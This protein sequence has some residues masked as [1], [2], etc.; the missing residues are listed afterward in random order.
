MVL[1]TKTIFKYTTSNCIWIGIIYLYDVS[2]VC[3]IPEDRSEQR[4]KRAVCL[5]LKYYYNRSKGKTVELS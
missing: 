3:I 4:I 2:Y 5:A 1:F